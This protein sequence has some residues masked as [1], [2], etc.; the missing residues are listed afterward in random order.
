MQK[1]YKTTAKRK[2]IKTNQFRKRKKKQSKS[3]EPFKLISKNHNL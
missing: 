3:G 1:I 2:M